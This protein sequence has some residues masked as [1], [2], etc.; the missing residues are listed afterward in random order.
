MLK[1]YFI[2]HGETDWN[3]EGRIQGMTDVTLNEKGLAQSQLLADRLAQEKDFVALYV[4]PLRRAYTTGEIVAR[5]LNLTPIT[6]PRLV[7]RDMGVV[8]GMTGDEVEQRFPE[9][10]IAW[11]NGNKR[12]PFPGEEKREDFQRRLKEFLQDL[13][14]SHTDRKVAVVTH[15]GAMGMIMA[16]VMSLDLERRFPF[17]FENASFSIVEF[18]G[19]VPRVFALNDTCHL[20]NCLQHPDEK[21]EFV[22]DAKND[23]A[24]ID[25]PQQSALL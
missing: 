16:T 8:E 10:R 14:A 9:I 1:V 12:V 2:R 15:G 11:K 20:R 6:D 22:L 17:W 18:G 24:G 23:S 25:I 21:A 5:G 4:S 7:E 19:P 13:R 3:A